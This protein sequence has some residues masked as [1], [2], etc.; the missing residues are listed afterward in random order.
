MVLL[1]WIAAVKNTHS[2][3]TTIYGN[4]IIQVISIIVLISLT[5]PFINCRLKNINHKLIITTN[6]DLYFLINIIP[7]PPIAI[8]GNVILSISIQNHHDIP[9]NHIKPSNNVVPIFAHKIIPIACVSHKTPDHTSARVIRAVI[10][11][12]CN[13]AVDIDQV[14]IAQILVVVNFLSKVLIAFE[15]CANHC[16]NTS[17]LNNKNPIHASI[18]RKVVHIY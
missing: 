12:L 3:N 18:V 2:I 7:N 15:L 10:A 17:K 9:I 16:S 4:Q 5:H 13:T 1:L 14:R 6:T 8:K 11:E